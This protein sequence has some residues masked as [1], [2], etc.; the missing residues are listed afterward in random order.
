VQKIL[1]GTNNKGKIREYEILF[2]GIFRPIP[3][4]YLGLHL[5]VNED[6]SSYEENA[7]IKLKYLKDKSPFPVI[8]DDSGLEVTSLNNEPGIFSARYSGRNSSDERNINKLLGK[9]KSLMASSDTIG[10]DGKVKIDRSARFVCSIAYFDSENSD[11][12]ITSYG[13]CHG[14][15]VDEGR[16][17]NGFGYDPVFYIEELSKTFAELSINQKSLISHRS[18]A[19]SDL[20]RQLNI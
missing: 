9:M 4:N 19:V 7:L 15:I 8:T 10:I 16:G 5:D 1:I 2:K 20:L 12:I 18:Q 14:L 13:E 11:E 6:G 17:Y 3:L